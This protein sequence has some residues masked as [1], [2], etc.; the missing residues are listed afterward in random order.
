[1]LALA[2]TAGTAW[3]QTTDA[4]AAVDYAAELRQM[5]PLALQGHAVAQFNMG[6]MHDFGQGTTKDTV[7]AARWYRLAA[8]QGH[9]GAQFNLGGL[10]FEGLGVPRDRV[11]ATM[12]FTLAAA[13]GIPGAAKNRGAVAGLLTSAEL[14]RARELAARCREQQFR[15]CD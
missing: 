15:D 7:Q 13:A 3:P 6:V 10:Y 11:R 4:G 9:G 5:E 2:C 12:W 1:M 8:G 14:A